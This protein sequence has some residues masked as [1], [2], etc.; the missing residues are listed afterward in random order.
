M[1][2]FSEMSLILSTL[3]T[4]SDFVFK[5]DKSGQAVLKCSRILPLYPAP[6]IKQQSTFSQ[7]Q[8]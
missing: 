3:K 2:I 1:F 8:Q 5:V 4:D 6:E 7:T